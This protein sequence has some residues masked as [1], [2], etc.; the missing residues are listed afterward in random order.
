MNEVYLLNQELLVSRFGLC[1]SR[2]DPSVFMMPYLGV[3]NAQKKI[4]LLSRT[5]IN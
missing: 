5:I 4:K 2:T 3:I 1:W